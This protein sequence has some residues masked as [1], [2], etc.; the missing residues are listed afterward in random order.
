MFNLHGTLASPP[1]GCR[2]IFQTAPDAEWVNIRPYEYSQ[3]KMSKLP[4]S[5]IE[6]K[7]FGS[8]GRGSL[9]E[10]SPS[11][12]LLIRLFSAFRFCTPAER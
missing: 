3:I 5:P 12:T 9:L 10:E 7:T 11:S 1:P 4:P 8:L 6:P 2:V